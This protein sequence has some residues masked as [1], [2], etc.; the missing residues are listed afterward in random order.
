MMLN[1]T[2]EEKKAGNANGAANSFPEFCVCDS[3]GFCFK[4]RHGRVLISFDTDVRQTPNPQY[5]PGTAWQLLL[6]KIPLVNDVTK[7]ARSNILTN[8]SVGM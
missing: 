2:C 1:V 8:P 7:T 4:G 3:N 6:Q 5:L